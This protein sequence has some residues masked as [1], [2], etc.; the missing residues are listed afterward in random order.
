MTFD[1]A[2]DRLSIL[3]LES[4]T[5]AFAALLD[6]SRVTRL[7]KRCGPSAV[8]RLV[9]A[10]RIYAVERLAWRAWPHVGKEGSEVVTPSVA[11]RDAAATVKA[12]LRVCLYE[13]TSFSV[14]PR[15]V[16]A[17]CS[18]ASCVPVSSRSR[19][20]RF[21]SE[22]ATASGSAISQR[23]AS[24]VG[25][26]TAITNAR[27]DGT[28]SRAIRSAQYHQTPKSTTTQVLKSQGCMLPQLVCLP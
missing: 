8:R 10:V 26:G 7:L 20:E 2:F 15:L 3:R 18:P 23:I 27:P 9:V 12:K 17:R 6:K 1:T 11:H 4:R 25:R 13:T 16:F 5:A 19:N 22:A 24:H 28:S 14:G 21:G